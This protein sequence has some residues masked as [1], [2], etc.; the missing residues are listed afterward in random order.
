MGCLTYAQCDAL[1]NQTGLTSLIT[2]GLI[3]AGPGS[4]HAMLFDIPQSGT[5]SSVSQVSEFVQWTFGNHSAFLK[6]IAEP[7]GPDQEILNALVQQTHLAGHKTATHATYLANY[8][9]A[10]VSNTDAIQHVPID[11]PVNSSMVQQILQQGQ[12]VT[13]T[14]NAFKYLLNIPGLASPGSNY[15]NAAQ[16]ANLLNKAGVQLLTGTDSFVDPTLPAYKIPFGIGL[17]NEFQYLVQ[18]GLTPLQVLIA[19]TS[20]AAKIHSLP[21]R[22]A[23]APGLRAD[24]LLIEGNPLTNISNTLNIKAVWVDGIQYTETLG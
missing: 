13:P 21:D 11:G 20:L 1:L 7:K 23:I 18:A 14:L 15:S 5:I 12:Y 17:H 22:G 10:I 4:P 6:M 9:Q 8:M 19:A 3:I 16:S 2:T 24:L